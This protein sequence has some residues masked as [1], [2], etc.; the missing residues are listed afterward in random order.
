[1]YFE[2]Q[3]SWLPFIRLQF[4]RAKETF[5]EFHTNLNYLKNEV[6]SFPETKNVIYYVYR[7]EMFI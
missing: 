4:Y 3:F 5:L 7:A 2:M 6:I 1:M